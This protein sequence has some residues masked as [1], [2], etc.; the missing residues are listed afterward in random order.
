MP[1]PMLSTT[2]PGSSGQLFVERVL[3]AGGLTAADVNWQVLPVPDMNAAFANQA[4][5]AAWH[6]EP[7]SSA[8]APSS[9][10]LRRS[11]LSTARR[12][13][14]FSVS[15]RMSIHCLNW[16]RAIQATGTDEAPK[17]LAQMK[18][19]PFKDAFTPHGMVRAD[20]RMVHDMYLVRTRTPGTPKGAWDLYDI[21]KIIPGDRA[22]RPI[23][24]GGCPLVSRS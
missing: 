15:P 3:A 23:D 13:R 1:W 9:T 20:G 10:L 18:S 24:K 19:A 17:V 14:R 16:L 22:F 5:D 12:S 11:S 7:F 2:T 4:I 6:Y 8:T 21:E